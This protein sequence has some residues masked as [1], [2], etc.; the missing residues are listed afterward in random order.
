LTKK[1]A[2]IVTDVL[3][4]LFRL[5]KER[6]LNEDSIVGAVLALL[7]A[8]EPLPVLEPEEEREEGEGKEGG[9]GD[10]LDK[11]VERANNQAFDAP[12]PAPVGWGKMEIVRVPL[13]KSKLTAPMGRKWKKGYC[14][15]LKYPHRLYTDG[16]VFGL[17]G[18]VR[19]GIVLVDCSGSMHPNEEIIARIVEIAP[20]VVV[21]LYAS[22]YGSL[23]RGRLVIVA[24]KG[25]MANVTE[26]M[27]YLGNGNVIDGPALQWLA[28]QRQAPKIWVSD[29]QVTGINDYGNFHL[30]V[31][32]LAICK[33]AR[34]KRIGSLAEALEYFQRLYGRR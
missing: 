6:T 26:A 32:A 17:K 27:S 18:K 22:A 14:G 24:E 34:I 13:M 19:G 3:H 31:E 9:D 5:F 12:N 20:A 21:A 30:T 33:R 23:H 11:L 25:R 8:F 15:V 7:L 10:G 29:G 28:S 4:S 2:E 16:E 1:D